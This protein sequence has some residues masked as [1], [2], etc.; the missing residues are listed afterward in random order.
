MAVRIPKTTTTWTVYSMK[1]ALKLVELGYDILKY[2]PNMQ[3]IT[4]KVF[5]FRVN[6]TFERDINLCIEEVKRERKTK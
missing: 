2:R 3:D 5:I 4:K 6:E 1:V